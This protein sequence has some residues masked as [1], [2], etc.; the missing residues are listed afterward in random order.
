MFFECPYTRIPFQILHYNQVGNIFGKTLQMLE[1]E[2]QVTG[3]KKRKAYDYV[4]TVLYLLPLDIVCSI[5]PFVLKITA[6]YYQVP[7][8][9]PCFNSVSL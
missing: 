6:L 7:S 5:F 9:K 1:G 8:H 4:I 2:Q 3:S